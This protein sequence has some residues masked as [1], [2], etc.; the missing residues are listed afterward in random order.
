[1]LRGS[2]RIFFSRCPVIQVNHPEPI[3]HPNPLSN[4]PPPAAKHFVQET[5]PIGSAM[6]KVLSI[7][8]L[9]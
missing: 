1:M 6:R 4:A 3:H 5:F 2:E 8:R 7:F 9:L